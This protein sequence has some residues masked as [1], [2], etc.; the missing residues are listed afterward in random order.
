MSSLW[1]HEARGLRGPGPPFW[2]DQWASCLRYAVTT[3]LVQV[4]KFLPITGRAPRAELGGEGTYELTCVKATV[5]Q[6]L[7]WTRRPRRALPL[8]MQ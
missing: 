4:K 3:R 1:G 6:V 8:M 7:R 2:K 5:V